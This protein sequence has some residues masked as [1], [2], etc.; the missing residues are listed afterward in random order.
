MIFSNSCQN[1]IRFR[2]KQDVVKIAAMGNRVLFAI[3]EATLIA[4]D[5]ASIAAMVYPDKYSI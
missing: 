2:M 1:K 4:E 3:K 5:K